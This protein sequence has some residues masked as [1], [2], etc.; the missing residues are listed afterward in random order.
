MNYPIN[1]AILATFLFHRTIVQKVFSPYS[2]T[3]YIFINVHDL[4]SFAINAYKFSSLKATADDS[5][6]FLSLGA[7]QLF[8]PFST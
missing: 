4:L 8:Y 7:G 2:T 3:F 6:R 5:V 1:A